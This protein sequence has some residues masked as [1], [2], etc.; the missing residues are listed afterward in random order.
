MSIIYRPKGRAAEYSRLAINHYVGCSHGC[1]YC[2]VPAITRN[3]E[4]FT[5]QSVR[6][7]VLWQLRREAPNFAGTDE[8][9]LLC[10]SCDPYQPLDTKEHVTREVIKILKANDIPFQV[11]TK[12]GLRAVCDFD[13]YGPTDAFAT[14]LTFLDGSKSQ[15]FEPL[16]ASPR[17]R[18][19]AIETAKKNGIQTWVSLEPVIDPEQSLEII[20]QT[21]HIVDHYKIGKVNHSDNDLP[22]GQWRKFG[23]EAIRL[24][25]EYETDYYIKNDLAKYLDGISFCSIDTR[26]IKKPNI[27]KKYATVEPARFRNES[28]KKYGE[29]KWEE[30]LIAIAEGDVHIPENVVDKF[31]DI[32]DKLRV[33]DEKGKWNSPKGKRLQIE[34][35]TIVNE[36]LDSKKPAHATKVQVAEGMLFY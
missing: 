33:L 1:N 24:C 30:T 13:L 19:L 17:H 14:T 6:K 16:A 2:Y 5:K 4:F 20:R 32:E 26:K 12:G 34:L 18:I 7:D 23:I 31:T 3:D 15:E 29:L 9:V 11:L 8:R 28:Y 25:R 22:A 35:D 21:H 36:Y 10:F 27:E